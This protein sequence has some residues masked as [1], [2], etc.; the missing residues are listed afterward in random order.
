MPSRLPY[1]DRGVE[2]E[3]DTVNCKK[4]KGDDSLAYVANVADGIPDLWCLRTSYRIC[5]D[6]NSGWLTQQPIRL[7]VTHSLRVRSLPHLHDLVS[8]S[9]SSSIV[10]K[11]IIVGSLKQRC[12]VRV[13]IYMT[14][15][16]ELCVRSNVRQLVARCFSQIV[17][18]PDS[19][20]VP[21]ST[22]FDDQ[23]SYFNK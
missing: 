2:V 15:L 7:R 16:Q 12:G 6:N 8:G 22:L 17:P 3:F 5:Q 21:Q 4:K 14:R 9:V 18:L 20:T 23:I 1:D 13:F 19:S 10:P 11:I